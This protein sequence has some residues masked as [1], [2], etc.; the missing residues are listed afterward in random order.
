MEMVKEK[1]Y[2]YF[3]INED[4]PKKIN[5]IDLQCLI[6]KKLNRFKALYVLDEVGCG[7]TI[8]GIYA[9]LDCI[10]DYCNNNKK[11]YNPNILIIAGSSKKLAEQWKKKIEALGLNKVI[12]CSSWMNTKLEENNNDKISDI[13]ITYAGINI[14]D[15]ERWGINKL[16][17]KCD[18]KSRQNVWDLVILDEPQQI[19][20][21]YYE[22]LEEKL[23]NKCSKVLFLTATP[24]Q[25]KNKRLFEKYFKFLTYE[26]KRQF[27]INNYNSIN[28]ILENANTQEKKIYIKWYD[29]IKEKFEW[30]DDKESKCNGKFDEYITRIIKDCNEL[31]KCTKNYLIQDFIIKDIESYYEEKDIENY[32]NYPNLCKVFQGRTINELQK[33]LG[34]WFKGKEFEDNFNRN[35]L[36]DGNKIDFFRNVDNY[37][38]FNSDNNRRYK[39]K[40]SIDI[41]LFLR[42]IKEK[43]IGSGIYG[44]NKEPIFYSQLIKIFN[45]IENINIDKVFDLVKRIVR[46]CIKEIEKY[47][48]EK[49]YKKYIDKID[50]IL[51]MSLFMECIKIENY[52]SEN[53][54]DFPSQKYIKEAFQEK[55]INRHI[56]KLE[57]ELN[58]ELE[59]IWDNIRSPYNIYGNVFL[60]LEKLQEKNKLNNLKDSL[61]LKKIEK[62]LS[63]YTKSIS[64]ENFEFKFNINELNEI[65]NFDKKMQL[66][67]ETLF[68]KDKIKKQNNVQANTLIFIQNLKTGK[69]L[70]DVLKSLQNI[71]KQNSVNYNVEV[72]DNKILKRI[73]KKENINEVIFNTDIIWQ[74]H[75]EYY[76]LY[77]P[78]NVSD[79]KEK[80]KSMNYKQAK[81]KKILI[82]TWKFIGVGYNIYGA[83]TII[84]YELP[85]NIS[86]L[87]QGFGRID[88]AFNS[89]ENIYYIYILP[90]SKDAYM[91]DNYRFFNL[92]YN[93]YELAKG[94]TKEIEENLKGIFNLPTRNIILSN[95]GNEEN[96]D[97]IKL[98]KNQLEKEL[99]EIE[100]INDD[101]NKIIDIL[102]DEKIRKDYF[103]EVKKKINKDQKL[104]IDSLDN[105]NNNQD[106][107]EF[108]KELNDYLNNY[109][110]KNKKE[111]EQYLQKEGF[112]NEY[113]NRDKSEED[114]Y[115][116]EDNYNVDINE[117]VDYIIEFSL[118]RYNKDSKKFIHD[119]IQKNVESRRNN[120]IKSIDLNKFKEIIYLREEINYSIKKEDEYEEIDEKNHLKDY[121]EYI[122]EINKKKNVIKSDENIKKLKEGVY[123]KGYKEKYKTAW[124]KIIDQ[125]KKENKE[126]IKNLDN[127][128]TTFLYFK[129]TEQKLDFLEPN[130]I[131]KVYRNI[132]DKPLDEIPEDAREFVQ[133]C[134]DFVEDFK[135]KINE[136]S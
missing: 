13:N 10:Y 66:L 29:H 82:G 109:L 103:W 44:P 88:R 81:N 36:W 107:D 117:L 110:I 133:E 92:C 121:L 127:L 113:K 3:C 129:G 135:N 95:Y 21:A 104:N 15:G 67:V 115:S 42:W 99:E 91:Y 94:N 84:A 119:D 23:K 9:I 22:R 83:D 123:K 122:Y 11:N 74:R 37:T 69:Y 134:R 85:T 12:E 71:L 7:K 70:Y 65:L 49:Y 108:K 118:K 45:D 128:S 18:E 16:L 40:N 33:L 89:Y 131:L 53:M 98:F 24:N 90:T 34:Y 6:V 19:F 25:Y 62:L 17:E 130:Q 46:G 4:N 136:N 64:D 86:I 14:D 59:G 50:N 63:Y 102:V 72:I 124:E 43:E 32:I 2:S 57:Y 27:L 93:T 60:I 47:D 5:F 112:I 77:D 111:F 1:A 132:F 75:T 52:I 96:K 114:Y 30:Y 41:K 55:K 20:Y 56:L 101:G 126:S 68:L 61:R 73:L 28:C 38:Y 58:D 76:N 100:K 87:E 54:L 35:A 105:I 80:E 8:Q 26:S 116:K 78:I 51:N 125:Y 120:K 79:E 31:E 97:F 39:L 106:L 48:D